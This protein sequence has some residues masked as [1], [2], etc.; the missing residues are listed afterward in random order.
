LR[1]GAGVDFIN[2]FTPYA[3]NLGSA[4]ILFAHIYSNLAL[5]ICA[6]L[7]AFSYWFGCVLCFTPYAQLLWNPPLVKG[8]KI[9]STIFQ[10]FMWTILKAAIVA[11][12]KWLPNIYK[13]QNCKTGFNQAC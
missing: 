9:F 3:W 12:N 4:P 11:K 5:C 8:F 10:F 6:Q 7:I 2:Q 1:H 13:K